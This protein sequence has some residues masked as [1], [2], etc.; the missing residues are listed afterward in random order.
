MLKS[1]RKRSRLGTGVLHRDALVLLC[2]YDEFIYWYDVMSD[3]RINARFDEQTTS[4]LQFLR[5]ALGDKSITDVLKVSVR[6][7]AQD[8]RERKRAKQQKQLWRDSGLIGCIQ[9]APP[10]LSVRYKQVVAEGLTS[11]HMQHAVSE[12]NNETDVK[13]DTNNVPEE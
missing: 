11:K 4:D 12:S 5:S 3:T 9:D 10:D 6:Q 13:I 2:L 8:I 7:L 1:S